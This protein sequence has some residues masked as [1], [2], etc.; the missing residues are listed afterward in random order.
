MP[1]VPGALDSLARTPTVLRALLDGVPDAAATTPD[2]D[3]WSAS[4]VV[5]HLLIINELG[6]DRR[7]RL[8][9]DE[10]EP[11]LPDV[12]E[13]ESLA[14]SGYRDRP[15]AELLDDFARQ[16]AATVDWIRGL[17]PAQFER[18]GNH[19]FV[20]RVTLCD[21]THHIAMHDLMHIAQIANL[22]AAPL[23]AARGNMAGVKS[24]EE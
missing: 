5:A 12:N 2:A 24:A 10:D 6:L 17:T 14:A 19:E 3:G 21:V 16:R 20:D 11:F 18:G 23:D 8:I 4:D 22:I 9:V 15:L 13:H 7:L 1:L